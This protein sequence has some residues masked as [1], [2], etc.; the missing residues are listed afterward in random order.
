[1]TEAVRVGAFLEAGGNKVFFVNGVLAALA[2][3]GVQI[4][5]LSGFSS[6]APIILA[7]H[8]GMHEQ[9][10]HDFAARL[11]ENPKNFYWFK[12]PHFPQ[13]R[14]YGAA[15]SALVHEHRAMDV[16]GHFAIYGAASSPRFPVLKSLLVSKFLLLRHSLGLNMLWLLRWMLGIEP[17]VVT[18]KH[19]M[20]RERLARFIMGSSSLYP[21]I[22]H[23]RVGHHLILEGA[24]LEIHPSEA[25]QACQKKI[26]IHTEQGT[27][28]VVGNM[29][30]IY[31]E[32][33]IPANILDYTNGDAVRALHAHGVEVAQ[34]NIDALREFLR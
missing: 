4:D 12:R 32:E 18:E 17:V 1:M 3:E 21:F 15:V 29:F 8:A 9:I 10:M 2:R 31:S 7:H 20:S 27:T 13:D 24:V 5:F 23:Y 14:I 25:L 28:G 19:D 30:H 11:D 16:A 22:S 6:A 34:R 33:P 26:V